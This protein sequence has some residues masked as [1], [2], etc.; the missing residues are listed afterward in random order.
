[1]NECVA[2]GGFKSLAKGRRVAFKIEQGPKD[3]AAAD[4]RKVQM[5]S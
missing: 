4:V 5:G 2:G 3:M 1:M